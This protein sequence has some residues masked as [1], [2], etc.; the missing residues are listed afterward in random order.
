MRRWVLDILW[1]LATRLGRRRTATAEDYAAQTY[2][3][4][5]YCSQTYRS[6]TYRSLRP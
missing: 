6:Q 1:R 3:S 2:R 4:Q 5:T